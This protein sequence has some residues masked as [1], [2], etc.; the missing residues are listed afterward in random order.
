MTASEEMQEI[1]LSSFCIFSVT[2]MEM[3]NE[4]CVQISIHEAI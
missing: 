3:L 1:I 2:Q 4:D